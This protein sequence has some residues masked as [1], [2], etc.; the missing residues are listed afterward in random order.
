MWYHVWRWRSK[1]ET[2]HKEYKFNN[3]NSN[4]ELTKGNTN[5]ETSRKVKL[6]VRPTRDSGLWRYRVMVNSWVVCSLANTFLVHGRKTTKSSLQRITSLPNCTPLGPLCYSFHSSS[7][8]VV[9]PCWDKN[10]TEMKENLY[11]L[12]VLCLF[13]S[14]MYILDVAGNKNVT[15]GIYEA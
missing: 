5:G 4:I 14:G 15:E 3:T 13:V 9:V 6:R 8:I 11:P 2:D 10:Y 1:W 7:A 12:Y